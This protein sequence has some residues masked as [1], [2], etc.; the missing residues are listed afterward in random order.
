MTG[1]L[2]AIAALALAATGLSAP[3]RAWAEKIEPVNGMAMH[4]APKYKAGFKNFAYVN[5]AAPKGGALRLGARGTFD[6]FNGFVIRGAAASSLGLIYDTLAVNSADEPFTVYGLIAESMEAPKDRSW[7]IFNLR[8]TARF[9]DGKP[10]TADDVIF[11]FNLLTK[12]GLPQYAYYYSAVVKVEKLALR[13]VKFT[14]RP[15][16][17]R[18][19]P[20]IVAQMVVL[21]K[22]YWEKRDFNNPTLE[23]PVGSGPYRIAKFE[24]GRRIA[25]ERVKDYW[26]KDL[27]VNVGR[28]NFDRVRIDYFRDITVLREA[29]KSGRFDLR[30]ENQAKAWATAYDIPAEKEGKLILLNAKHGRSAGMQAFVLNNRISKFKDPRVRQ[31]IGYAFDFNYTN[32]TL[33]FGQYLRNKSF[34]ENSELAARGLPKGEEL[35]I[36]E[37]FRGRIPEAVFTEVYDLPFYE[38]PGNLRNGLR[39]AFKL[40]KAAG[41]VVKNR[42]LVNAKTGE[43]MRFEILSASQ[44]FERIYL[45]FTK[46]LRR[47]GIDARVRLVDPAQYEERMKRF[48]FEMTTLGWGQALSPGNEQR[49]M[50]SSAAADTEGSRNYIGIKNKVIDELIELIISSPDRKAL[51]ARTRALDRVLLW[52]QY[53]IPQWYLNTDRIA[54]W[55]KFGRPGIETIQGEDTFTWWVDKK[56]KAALGSALKSD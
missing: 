38:K 13:R 47:L 1:R 21:P 40:F 8:K 27:P 32:K 53:V 43:A 24:A 12:K 9:N 5:P 54:Y 23:P 29:F 55:N 34:F 18:E 50:W 16:E 33:F 56:K 20:L 25:Y 44:E 17:N 22:H 19:M 46:N 26:G 39:K 14:F 45:P 15:G 51:V 35:K 10:I 31:A 30:R 2:L 52:N 7:I 37:K 36:L 4:G 41:W 6:S 3:G 11:T 48:D 42:K 49:N 28:Y